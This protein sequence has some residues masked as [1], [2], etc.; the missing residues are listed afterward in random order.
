MKTL[1]CP[2][3]RELRFVAAGGRVLFFA[4]AF[5]AVSA[6]A[7]VPKETPWKYDALVAR[8]PFVPRAAAATAKGSGGGRYRFTGFVIL[9]EKVRAGIENIAQNKSWL[10]APGETV[11]ELT[12][13]EI[14]VKE[15]R[16]VVMVGS[17]TLRLDLSEASAGAPAVVPQ[18]PGATAATPGV[19]VAP[20]GDGSARRR[21]IVPLR[22]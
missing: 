1:H 2:R 7:E 9:G 22:R 19:V 5:C 3:W 14:E 11:E 17:E 13:R 15:K 20:G 10:L 6:R 8:Q 12:L 21:I 16:V 18:P 4:G